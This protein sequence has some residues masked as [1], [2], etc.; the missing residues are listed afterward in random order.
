MPKRPTI[1]DIANA[2]GV[3]VSTVHRALKGDAN[4]TA[5]TRNRVLQMAKQLEYKPNLAARFL[6]S[7]RSLRVSINTPKGNTSFWDEVRAGVDDERQLLNLE[8]VHVEYRTYSRSGEDELAAFEQAVTDRVD[9][10]I[11][12]PSDPAMLRPLMRRATRQNL[13]V[14][15]VATDAPETGRLAVVSVDT[16]ASGALAAEIMARIG[17]ERGTVAVTLFSGSVTEHAEKY[18]AFKNTMERYYPKVSVLPPLED[19]G[20]DALCYKEC[21]RL[22]KEHT[23]LA[24]I[25]VATEESMPV[26]RAARD[27]KRLSQLTLVTTDLFPKLVEEIR[28]GAV[29]ATIYQRPRTQGRTAF[30]TLHQY[31]LESECPPAQ[32]TFAPHLVMRGNLEFFLQRSSLEPEE[33]RAR[34]A[35]VSVAARSSRAVSSGQGVSK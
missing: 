27:A 35:S 34:Q 16:M 26:I 21:R 6:S 28:S 1:V 29:T 2:L 14:V 24:G 10:I 23:D 9:G 22:L 31:L 32:I 18:Q 5:M 33:G 7:K 3:S 30:R 4:T 13:P 25:Y 8:S 11:A 20:D 12:F 17:R 19:H 15:F